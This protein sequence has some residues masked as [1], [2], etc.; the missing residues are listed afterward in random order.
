MYDYYVYMLR[1]SDGSY[2]TG[3]TNSV[4]RRLWQHQNGINPDCYT[5]SR[6]P[7]E[8]VYSAW[9]TNVFEA[10]HWE[11]QIKRWSRKKK[12]ALIRGEWEEIQRLAK[13]DFSTKKNRSM[14]P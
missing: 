2:Y 5:F 9:F 4:E 12:E 8:L 6:R 7:V 3:I 1:C 14:S 10:I 13:K 11:K